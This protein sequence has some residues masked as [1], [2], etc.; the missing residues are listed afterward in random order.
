[1]SNFSSIPPELTHGPFR[2]AVA[3]GAGVSHAVL[4]GP[5]FRRMCRGVYMD[6][7]LEVTFPLRL[8]AFLLALPPLTVV[9]HVSAA[10]LW[11][12]D[13]LGHA[14]LEF[15]GTAAKHSALPGVVLHRR[16]ARITRYDRA[17]FPATGPDRTFVDCALRLSFV[18]LVQLGDHLIHIGA[19]TRDVLADYCW[20]RHLHGVQRA[21]RAVQWVR[22][23]AESPR[24]SLMR[25]LLVF[26]RLPEPELNV[27]ITDASGT[28]LARVDMLF[29]RHKVIVEYDGRQHERDS[30]QWKRDRERREVLEALG[31]R[32]I[33]IAAPDFHA[34]HQ[35]ARRV[36][37]ALAQRGY[38]GPAPVT[39]VVWRRWFTPQLSTT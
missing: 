38:D 9:S 16:E 12:F 14:D 29:R 31:Y 3:A 8:Q 25:L 2:I 36:H 21:R 33:V 13:P 37:E 20:S 5:Q 7:R 34:P 18:E 22:A 24:E 1:M 6:A 11:G 23:G 15:S 35:I 32:L 26:A 19:T 4:R 27:W 17:G 30:R 28:R 10:R 39:S